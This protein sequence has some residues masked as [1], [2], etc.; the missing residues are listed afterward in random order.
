PE[1]MALVLKDIGYR[2]SYKDGNKDNR[3][4]SYKEYN[5]AMNF[6]PA[7]SNRAY[8]PFYTLELVKVFGRGKTPGFML[9]TGHEITVNE[10]F[11]FSLLGGYNFLPDTGVRYSFGLNFKWEIRAN[12]MEFTYSCKNYKDLGFAHSLNYLLRLDYNETFLPLEDILLYIKR[13][14]IKNQ[15]KKAFDLAR[16]YL[17][18][19]PRS[20]ELKEIFDKLKVMLFK[21]S[22]IEAK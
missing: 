20:K 15:H 7:I 19:Y 16:R 14:V 2:S 17:R 1:Q 6:L 11:A 10:L 8:Q 5:I 21:K 22:F 18:K 4:K 13:L 3:G 12:P 9:A